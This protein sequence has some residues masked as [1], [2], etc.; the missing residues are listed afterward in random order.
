MLTGT[1]SNLVL[2][3]AIFLGVHTLVSGTPLRGVLVRTIGLRAYLALF[4]LT[5][6]AGLVWMILAY[7][8]APF[9]PIWQAP[10]LG[11]VGVLLMPV[12][13]LFAIA[14]YTTKGL[15]AS[16]AGLAGVEDRDLAVGIGKITRHPFLWSVV[17]WSGAHLLVNGDVASLI[18]F[19]TFL[20]LGLVGPL[21]IDAKRRRSEPE[22]WGSRC[23]SNVKLAL[24]RRARRSKPSLSWRD[25]VVANCRS[26]GRLCRAPGWTRLDLR[27]AGAELRF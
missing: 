1:T 7:R 8:E 15:T 13:L 4:S 20:I 14:G 22:A 12:A 18:L 25:R 11:W 19:A 24:R 26:R 9:I 6:L 5:S 16:G 2:P 10:V 3:A 23:S 21:L 17:L 27:R